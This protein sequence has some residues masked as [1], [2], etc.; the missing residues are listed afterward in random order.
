MSLYRLPLVVL[1]E[2]FKSIFRTLKKKEFFDILLKLR[3]VDKHFKYRSD[4]I[5]K[6]FFQGLSINP[7]I[8][9][10]LKTESKSIF[11]ENRLCK[12]LLR[13]EEAYV[14]RSSLDLGNLVCAN[15]NFI[16]YDYCYPHQDDT[17]YY[18]EER[19]ISNPEI[20]I[21]CWECYK[22]KEGESLDEHEKYLDCFS[23]C[24]KVN[25]FVSSILQEN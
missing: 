5:L 20:N 13:S 12:S 17:I 1:E 2:I 19:E 24:D 3:Q 6:K 22:I 11:L 18:L 23:V 10:R 4:K 14:I 16:I 25:L 15:C 7:Y 8:D 9:V 21:I